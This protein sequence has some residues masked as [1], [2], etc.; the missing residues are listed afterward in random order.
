MADEKNPSA[1]KMEPM[2]SPAPKTETKNIV[3]EKLMKDHERLAA[4]V[5]AIEKWLMNQ[6][7]YRPE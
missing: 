4:R 3:N 5:D 2:K 1:N 6:H 7:G